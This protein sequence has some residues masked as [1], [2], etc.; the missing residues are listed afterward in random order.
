MTIT[1]TEF[2]FLRH[3][4]TD[5]NTQGLSQ[6]RTE[7]P[8]NARG[9]AQ[10]HAAAG[11]LAHRG[12]RAIV[13]SPLGRA[14]RTAAIVGAALGVPVA[15]QTD[16]QEASFGDQEGRPIATW[17]DDWVAGGYTPE[18][19]ESFAALQARVIPAVNRALAGER[20]VLIVAHGAMFRAVRAAMGLS[21]LVRTENGVP[22]RC[23]PAEPWRLEPV[24]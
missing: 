12:I 3:G 19:G 24:A 23:V 18:G 8:L 4:E 11:L 9:V 5:W 16:L 17:Y 10:A 1:A 6:G 2:I 15:T 20:L 21:A 13:A 14:Q 22:L 7:V